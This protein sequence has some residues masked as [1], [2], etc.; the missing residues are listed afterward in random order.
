M[1]VQT[2]TIKY[3]EDSKLTTSQFRFFRLMTA[4]LVGGRQNDVSSKL[5]LLPAITSSRSPLTE[6]DIN[7]HKSNSTYFSDLDISRSNLVMLLF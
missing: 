7:L 5:L 3:S 4:R 6:C 2:G 1:L